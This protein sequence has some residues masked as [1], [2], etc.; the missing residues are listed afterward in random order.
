VINLSRQIVW[1][2]V[3]GGM[4]VVL[5][6]VPAHAQFSPRDGYA[7]DGSYRVQVELTPY[8]WL[9]AVSG[10]ARIGAAFAKDVS[11]GSGPPSIADLAHSLHGAV[12]GDGLLRYGPWSAELDLQWLDAFHKSAVQVLAAGP[13]GTLKDTVTLFRIAPGLGYQVYSGELAGI[14]TTVDARAGFSVL[15]WDV[16][17]KVE[18][19]PF[20][21]ADVSHSFAQPW[22][23][24]RADFYPGTNWRLELGAMAE[25]FGVDGGVWGWGASA[26]VSYSVTSWLDVTGGIRALSSTGRGNGSGALRRSIDFT[27]YGPVIGFGF[28]F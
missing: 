25:G 12:V 8:L 13:G 1:R 10:T 7:P 19:S 14:P 9:P 5:A 18:G 22:A 21:G 26:L 2:A 27:A 16:T 17:A 3:A 28:R 23:G 6:A 24:F 4:L 20:P 15:S 11:F